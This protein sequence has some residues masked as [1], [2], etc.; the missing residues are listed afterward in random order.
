M[1]YI[2]LDSA[3][4]DLFD[5]KPVSISDILTMD[6]DLSELYVDVEEND[7]KETCS[8]E[9][10]VDMTYNVDEEIPE[11]VL[12]VFFLSLMSF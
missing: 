2:C 12:K 1:F 9:S 10:P 3:A 5:S 4:E 8:Q 11:D 7:I 6:V